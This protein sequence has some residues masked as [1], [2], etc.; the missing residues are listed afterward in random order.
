M[1]NT[2]REVQR[3]QGPFEYV[4]IKRE[5]ANKCGRKTLFISKSPLV[6]TFITSIMHYKKNL[7][8]VSN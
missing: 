8:L 7:I 2:V 4:N 5:C 6:A 1:T 3:C